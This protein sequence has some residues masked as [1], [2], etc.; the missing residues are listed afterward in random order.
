MV[1]ILMHFF[2]LSERGMAEKSS[3]GQRVYTM[4]GMLSTSDKD[5]LIKFNHLPDNAILCKKGNAIVYKNCLK[6]D[7]KIGNQRDERLNHSIS[8]IQSDKIYLFYLYI[9]D[10]TITGE[11]LELQS[12]NN[13]EVH[14]NNVFLKNGGNMD[15]LKKQLEAVNQNLKVINSN[16]PTTSTTTKPTTLQQKPGPKPT[17][18]VNDNEDFKSTLNDFYSK[19]TNT[20]PLCVSINSLRFGGSYKISKNIEIYGRIENA[21]NKHYD[22][23]YG[24]GE[25]DLSVY[26]GLKSKIG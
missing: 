14:L 12:L 10:K 3:R 1:L 7:E 19:I 9:R 20:P 23:I 25:R 24:Y 8:E 21:L 15:D 17:E 11:S 26:V 16:K 2:L 4:I 18:I 5:G 13:V 22:T 6:Y